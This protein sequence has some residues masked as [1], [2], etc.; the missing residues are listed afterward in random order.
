MG[1]AGCEVWFGFAFRWFV[2]AHQPIKFPQL[3][4][5]KPREQQQQLC[6]LVLTVVGCVALL[7]NTSCSLAVD[8]VRSCMTQPTA[9]ELCVLCVYWRGRERQQVALTETQ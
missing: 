6:A 7:V 5:P 1:R 9:G 4:L 3:S 2:P 8:A